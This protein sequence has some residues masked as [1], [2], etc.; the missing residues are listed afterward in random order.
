MLMFNLAAL[1][2]IAQSD[3]TVAKEHLSET[4][5]SMV[6]DKDMQP[7]LYRMNY[8]LSA[9]LSLASTAANIYAVPNIIKA[10]QPLSDAELAGL[11]KSTLSGFDRWALN[12]DPSK[13]EINYQYSDYLLPAIIVST[14]SLAFD[15]KIRRDW[16]R[17]LVL[18]Y[19]THA[20]TFNL[21][22]F[23][24]FGPAFQNKVRPFAYY[25]DYYTADERRGGNNR[26][27]LYS[28]HTASAAAASFFLVKVYTDYHPEIGNRKYLY[29]ALATLPPLAEGY[30]RMKALAHF[31][32]D[33][34][35][36]LIIGATCGIVVPELH[37]YKQQGIKLG[38]AATP[39][40]PGINL[41]WQPGL[42]NPKP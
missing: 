13:R 36:G 24:F 12:Q 30:M 23:S 41:T 25:D 1:N 39:V 34:V 28:G 15:K 7:Q 11:D 10:K 38:V 2:A 18:Y 16:L 8:W 14:G 22:N 32:S 37:R 6:T 42:K 19:E 26:N 40:G 17:L 9:G 31:P 4:L 20:I 21:Y 33:I 3:T 5:D 27:S 29:Y 35:V